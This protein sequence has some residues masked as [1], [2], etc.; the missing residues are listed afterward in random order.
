MPTLPSEPDQ[1]IRSAA[2]GFLES[3]WLGPGAVVL[4][5]GAGLLLWLSGRRF[6]RPGFILL[7]AIGGAACLVAAH[8]SLDL[9]F[10]G[11]IPL[12]VGLVGGALVGWL[13]F[14]VLVAQA[15]G[16]VGCVG[17][18]FAV[19]TMVENVP[20]TD[21]DPPE[22]EQVQSEASPT[23][24]APDQDRSR[25]THEAIVAL[26]LR[27]KI[28]DLR[29]WAMDEKS[30]AAENAQTGDAAGTALSAPDVARTFAVRV[31][32]QAWRF[33]NDDLDPRGRAALLLSAALG[34]LG[35]FVLGLALPQKASAITTAMIGPA[36]WLPAGIWLSERF[37]AAVERFTPTSPR[38]WLIMW[39]CL[40]I[41]GAA[42]QLMGL[43]QRP[44]RQRETKG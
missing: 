17:L 9:G 23:A 36:I 26:L 12:A 44:R 34:Y 10:D 35:G 38:T 15:L 27:Q 7:G 22:Q 21:L 8:R 18:V 13:F 39:L 2:G 20:K 3:G 37:G 16:L 25:Q 1:L 5:F 14:R 29:A 42:F 32:E 11:W 43:R 40:S 28:E 19:A 30:R 31:G 4:I 6:L 33:W 41:A 24:A